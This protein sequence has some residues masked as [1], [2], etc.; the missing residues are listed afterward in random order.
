[1]SRLRGDS[2]IIRRAMTTITTATTTFPLAFRRGASG[3]LDFQE[4]GLQL[5]AR[6][7]E[8]HSVVRGE[9]PLF[10][11][12]ARELHRRAVS[13]SG[14]CRNF[15]A[16]GCRSFVTEITYGMKF[17][18][19]TTRATRALDNAKNKPK[20]RTPRYILKGR[21]A[22]IRERPLDRSRLE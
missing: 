15:D 2:R 9:S 13:L 5:G 4:F 11:A 3:G 18:R 19:A 14:C 20:R 10:R 1:M 8:T 6:G 12:A 17:L 21:E 7:T 16:R 22:E